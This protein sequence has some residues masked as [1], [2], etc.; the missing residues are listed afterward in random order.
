MADEFT[1][2]NNHCLFFLD[3]DGQ[4]AYLNESC[5][6][7]L[8]YAR[9]ELI[10]QAVNELG[11]LADCQDLKSMFNL[12]ILGKTNLIE[13]TVR[14]KD[15]ATFPAKIDITHVLY[16]RRMLFRCDLHRING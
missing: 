11:M 13:T 4:F 2:A 3:T 16:G 8:G 12:C 10:A 5:C 1:T 14:R 6:M 9:E 15:G 7:D